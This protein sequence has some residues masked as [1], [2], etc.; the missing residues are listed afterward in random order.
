MFNKT[1]ILNFQTEVSLLEKEDLFLDVASVS[2]SA[3]AKALWADFG[4][5][6]ISKG[7]LIFDAHICISCLFFASINHVKSWFFYC[8]VMKARVNITDPSYED[9][10]N[11]VFA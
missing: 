3:R 9:W 10:L 8:W 7:R 11:R 5:Y 4:D 1:D 6:H 2:S